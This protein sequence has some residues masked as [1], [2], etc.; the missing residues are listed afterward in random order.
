MFKKKAQSSIELL[1]VVGIALIILLPASIAFFSYAQST[2]S[3]VSASQINILGT[4]LISKAEE[5]YALG[6]SSWSTIELSVPNEVLS[7]GIVNQTELFIN[8]RTPIGTSQAVFFSTRIG[9]TNSV[10]SCIDVCTLNLTPG[11]NR[12]RIQSMGQNVSIQ[13]R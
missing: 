8:Y 11:I 5:M 1:M 13:R 3:M 12:F 7:A 9:V 10:D 2:T 4:E 6:S